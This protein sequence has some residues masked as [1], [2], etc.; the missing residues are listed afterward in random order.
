MGRGVRGRE[1]VGEEEEVEGLWSVE[2]DRLAGVRACLCGLKTGFLGGGG[3][4]G[5]WRGGMWGRLVRRWRGGSLGIGIHDEKSRVLRRVLG[6]K[7]MREH[8]ITTC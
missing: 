7:L 1:R 8:S 2:L 6:S 4:F 3:G 5:S